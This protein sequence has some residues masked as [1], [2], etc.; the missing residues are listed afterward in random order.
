MSPHLFK[1]VLTYRATEKDDYKVVKWDDVEEFISTI[2]RVG[3]RR[4]SKDGSGII[5]ATFKPHSHLEQ[6]NLETVTALI[7]DVDGKFKRDGE[8]VY[9]P[10][11][12]D[13]FIGHLPFRGLAHTSYNHSPAHPKFRV[14]LPLDRPVSMEEHRRLW[15]W[16]FEKTQHK[17]DRACKNPDRMFIC[18]VP[19]KK[20]SRKGGRGCGSSTARCSASTP[21]L[22]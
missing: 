9:E 14:I 20:H 11:D 12:P 3:H 17:A 7:L 15:Y 16:A 22:P 2:L 18:R 10:V 21:S 1:Y 19:P 5:G 6:K 4:G 13:E 8:V